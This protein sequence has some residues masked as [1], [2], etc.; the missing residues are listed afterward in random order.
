MTAPL[1]LKSTRVSGIKIA[2]VVVPA[3]L[4]AS[5]C[6]AL[7]LGA[8]AEQ[9]KSSP[10]V[11]EITLP[12]MSDYLRKLQT[13]IAVREVES[14]SGQHALRQVAAM[15]QGTLGPENLAYEVFKSQRDSAAGLLWPTIWIKA[16]D[17]ES[18]R[19]VVLAVPQA[20]EGA[21]LAFA[22]GFAEYLSSHETPI[23]VR[24]VIYPP[25]HDAN[26]PKWIWE[27][28]GAKGEEMA[29]FLK[30]SAGGSDLAASELRVMD[31]KQDLLRKL[32]EKR[33][34]PDQV[35]VSG[36]PSSYFEFRLAGTG[37]GAQRGGRDEQAQHL[38]RMMPVVKSLL[39]GLAE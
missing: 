10:I 14:K 33:A 32:K 37:A 16:G 5:I 38:I 15:T 11:G 31:G 8:N 7:Y 25:L 26:L 9:E 22:Y 36:E 4:I 19:P 28:C 21:G 13:M 6:I 34:W 27:R 12:E 2:I 18:E 17:E 1:E 24:I 20:G 30:L 29:G 35:A 39:E 23:G 3:L